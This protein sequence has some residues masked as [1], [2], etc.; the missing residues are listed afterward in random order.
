MGM[1]PSDSM[2]EADMERAIQA[3]LN[4]GHNLNT[5]DEELQR[6]LEESRRNY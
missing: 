6:I 4:T 1:N 2:N 3:S 5:E